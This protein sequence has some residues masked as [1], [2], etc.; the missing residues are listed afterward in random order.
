MST[1]ILLSVIAILIAAVLSPLGL[2][3]IDAETAFDIFLG[4]L[5]VLV[6]ALLMQLLEF[7]RWLAVEEYKKR[8]R[9]YYEERRRKIAEAALRNVKDD[10]GDKK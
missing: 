5:A 6:A 3:V 1:I 8:A 10:T 2:S 9:E 4:A 7:N